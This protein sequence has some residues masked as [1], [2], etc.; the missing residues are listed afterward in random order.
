[1]RRAAI[2]LTLFLAGASAARAEPQLAAFV[3]D[4]ND[5]VY[6]ALFDG[7]AVELAGCTS[8]GQAKRLLHL[9]DTAAVSEAT[10]ARL[11]A[12]NGFGTQPR[13]PCPGTAF[14]IDWP[15][16]TAIWADVEASGN[17]YLP[18][19]SGSGYFAVPTAC[20]E[21]KAALAVRERLQLPGVLQGF[22]A[23]PDAGTPFVLDCGRGDLGGPSDVAAASAARWS[24]HRFETFLNA[25]SIGDTIYVAR[26]TPPGEGAQPSYLPIVRLDGKATRDI[27]ADAAAADA[28]E[29]KLR[30]FFG[31]AGTE[32]V[33][34]LGADAVAALRSAPFVDLCLSDC[35]GYQRD[36]AAFAQPGIDPFITTIDLLDVMDR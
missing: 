13:L 24:L 7:K 27:I 11:Q 1:M 31:I 28:A 9:P 5:D 16:T 36:H 3:T 35:D 29:K 6:V 14:D 12:E 34:L 15:A 33:T 2:L 23:P 17:Y 19:P 22:A 10:L 18:S 25:E 21:I 20:A 4:Q 30:A 32:T 26:F 8:A